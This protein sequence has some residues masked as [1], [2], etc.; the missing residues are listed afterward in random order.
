MPFRLT[1][2]FVNFLLPLGTEGIL[3]ST[4]VRVPVFLSALLS[5][6]V[7]ALLALAREKEALLAVMEV[8]VKE[9]LL[10]WEK[11][12]LKVFFPTSP[13]QLSSPP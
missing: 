1:R 7:F 6:Q 3:K 13:S 10:E 4:M 2:Q 5:L 9:P 12:A 8:F 11:W